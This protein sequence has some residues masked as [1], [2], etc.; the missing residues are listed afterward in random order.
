MNPNP[1]LTRRSFLKDCLMAGLACAFLPAASTYARRWSGILVPRRMIGVDLAEGPD[2]TALMLVDVSVCKTD[3][4]EVV[5]ERR[6]YMWRPGDDKMEPL[7]V[8]RFREP[9]DGWEAGKMVLVTPDTSF[10]MEMRRLAGKPTG[11]VPPFTPE[12]QKWVL[13]HQRYFLK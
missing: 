8:L 7:D 6:Q 11:G 4:G 5:G 13:E 12:A 10:T 9:A 3:T 2:E 1:N